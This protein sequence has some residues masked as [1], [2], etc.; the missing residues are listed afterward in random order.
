MLAQ[1]PREMSNSDQHLGR[2]R[3]NN[4]WQSSF[5]EARES[6]VLIL[7]WLSSSPLLLSRFTSTPKSAAGMLRAYALSRMSRHALWMH[8]STCEERALMTRTSSSLA[9]RRQHY[10]RLVRFPFRAT[11][12]RRWSISCAG[13]E[14][15]F[16]SSTSIFLSRRRTQQ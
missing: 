1:R 6:N 8:A 11:R 13:T 16:L 14:Q 4:S 7:D 10:K 15:G 12:T 9:W 5:P 3:S 2:E